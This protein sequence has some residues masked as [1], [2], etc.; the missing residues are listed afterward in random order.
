VNPV[1]E[2][3]HGRK[4]I[5]DYEDRPVPEAVREQ[6]I[7]AALRAPTAGNMM[8]YSIIHVSDPAAKATLARTCDNQPFIAKAP[9]VLLFL[10]DYQ[11][12]YDYFRLS[13][14]EELSAR[15]GRPMQTPEEGDL[16]LACCDALIAAQ[17][18]VLAAESLGLGSCYIGDILENCEEHR[19][20]FSL[21]RYAFPIGL[22][23]FGYPT[24]EQ[25]HRPL[26]SRFDR[27]YI[28]FEN[29]YRS[30]QPHE[31]QTMF[32]QAQ[33]EMDASGSAPVGAGNPGQRIYLRKFT[34]EFSRE[35]RRSVRLMLQSWAPT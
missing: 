23:C 16:L 19:R 15:R 18:A 30:L 4:S 26:T 27:D 11:R 6:I 31:F 9:L 3:I 17:T 12:W 2:L 24:Q 1:L 13:G 34:A 21:P 7:Q 20:L 28:V 14:A 35:M 10:A 33:K 29:S 5:R 25:R 22:L 8:L 32:H